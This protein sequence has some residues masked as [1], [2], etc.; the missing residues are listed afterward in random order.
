M[1]CLSNIDCSLFKLLRNLDLPKGHF[2]VF[3]SGPLIVRG[4]ISASNDLDVLCR[5]S[6]WKF[7]QTLG[8]LEYLPE[9]E[10]EIV[11][12]AD[13]QLT[14]GTRWGIGSF[15]T[16]ALINTAE[17]MDDL[18]FVQLEHVASYKRVSK[19]PKDQEHLRAMRQQGY[20]HGST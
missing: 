1:A 19:R 2:A 17:I 3:G 10:L 8:K 4:I 14:F 20:L 12:L 5:G 6:A 7:V 13:G 16:D 11:S 9:Y 15:D 18:P